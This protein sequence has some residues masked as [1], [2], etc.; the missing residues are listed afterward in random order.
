M[1]P[2]TVAG[3]PGTPPRALT[4]PGGACR[5]LHGEPLEETTRLGVRTWGNAPDGPD[6]LLVGT[7]RMESGVSRR[8]LDALPPLPPLPHLPGDAWTCPLTPVLEDGINR[9]APGRSVVLDRVPD[10]LPI[11][12]VRT[13]FARP[14]AAAALAARTGV[15]RAA[16]ARRFTDLVGEPPMAYLTGWRLALAADLL[17]ETDRTVERIARQVGHGG[18]FAFSAA[19]KRVRGVS[20]QECRSAYA[21]KL[22]D[23]HA[24]S[25]PAA[26]ART[27]SP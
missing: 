22:P 9:D 23:R 12:A 1:P 5:T 2:Y 25:P 17:R 19:F 20:P 16:P 3:D 8:L 4:G 10:P 6:G 7:H 24:S 27:L 14:A 21:G 13:R 18:A 26:S 15:P 11:A